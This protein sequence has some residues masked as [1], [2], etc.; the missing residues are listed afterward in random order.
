M[1]CERQGYRTPIGH[2]LK[3]SALACAG[4]LAACAAQA[5]IASRSGFRGAELTPARGK[6]DFTLESDQGRSFDFRRDTRGTVTLLYFGYT[7]CPDVCPVHLANIAAVLHG[8]PYEEQRRIRVVFVTTDPARDTTARL[9]SWLAQFDSSFVGLRGSAGEVDR[10]QVALGLAPAQRE[11]P[12][13]SGGALG[14]RY[15]VGRA[16]QVL[17]FTADDSLRVEYPFGTRQQDWA[18]DL[19][20]LLADY[21]PTR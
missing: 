3:V 11:Q 12:Q 7:N 4:V 21:P 17:A 18:H 5:R 14:E 16:G 15:Q 2:A 20:K 19:P 10:I 8:L 6:P 13:S 9:R 1:R